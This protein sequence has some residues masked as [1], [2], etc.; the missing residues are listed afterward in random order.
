VKPIIDNL[1]K[2]LENRVRLAIMAVLMVNE[3]VD[4]NT[5]K[6]LLQLT[7]GNLATHVALLER[8]GYLKVHKR[9]V[10]KKPRT[11]YA[12]TGTGRAA[13]REHVDALEQLIRAGRD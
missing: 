11:T 3:T 13:F 7:D 8:E 9:F 10:G 5:L 6:D 2:T 4:F 12:A 1:S